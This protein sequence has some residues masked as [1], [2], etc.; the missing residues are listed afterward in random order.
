MPQGLNR[1]QLLQLVV[2]ILIGWGVSHVLQR[3]IPI[4]RDISSNQIARALLQDRISPS[5]EVKHP[6][7]TLM[8]FTDY[9][10]P[11]CKLSSPAMEAAVSNDGH[12]RVVYKDWP[13]FGAVSE[14]AAR[15]AIAA[16]RQGI[17]PGLHRRLM[18]ERRPLDELVLREAVEQS[19]GNWPQ[20]QRDLQLHAVEI[21]QQLNLNRGNAFALGL[22]GTPAYL[23]GPVLV[24]GATDEAGFADAL[25]AGRSTAMP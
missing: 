9:Q 25:A 1:K 16:D 5:R 19:G 2:V 23:A 4:G 21:D 3:T 11:A 8:I 24:S 22:V 20:I 6:T 12:V 13:I 17:Y 14:H 18:D 10:C 15:I 7:L